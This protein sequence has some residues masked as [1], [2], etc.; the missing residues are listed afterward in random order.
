MLARLFRG[1][2][3]GLTMV[4]AVS[5]TPLQASAAGG[6][7]PPS[8]APR[9]LSDFLGIIRAMTGGG[10]IV[11]ACLRQAGGGLV[12][13]LKVQV[14]GKVITVRIDAATGAPR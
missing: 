3:V 9:G 14:G 6:C 2:I 7:L 1:L 10:V 4:L 11:N 5:A 8:Q 13:E 12:Y